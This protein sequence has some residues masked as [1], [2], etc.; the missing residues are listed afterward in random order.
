MIHENVEEFEWTIL[1]SL[2]GT[3]YWV[4]STVMEAADLG[5]PV[6]RRRRWTMLVHKQKARDVVCF[7]VLDPAERVFIG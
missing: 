4:Y 1:Q 6:W 5:W 3:I 7:D 2:L